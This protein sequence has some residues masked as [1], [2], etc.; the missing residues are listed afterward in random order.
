M[1]IVFLAE[2]RPRPYL[3][4]GRRIAELRHYARLSQRE[5]AHNAGYSEGYI[6]R[7]E[8]GLNRPEPDVLR[9]IARALSADYDE[10]AV[11]AGYQRGT[12]ELQA[13]PSFADLQA[14][15]DALRPYEVLVYDELPTLHAGVGSA[16][17]VQV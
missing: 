4:L 17:A 6:P 7:I 14:Q 3:A 2:D 5:L 10:L 16:V 1:V 8:R 15:A 11:L 13:P 9:A 12:D